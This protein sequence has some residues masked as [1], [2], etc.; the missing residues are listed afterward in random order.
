MDEVNSHYELVLPE[1]VSDSGPKTLDELALSQRGVRDEQKDHC[2]ET[3]L[4]HRHF[5]ATLST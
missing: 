5:F 1:V 2:G 4:P 3:E